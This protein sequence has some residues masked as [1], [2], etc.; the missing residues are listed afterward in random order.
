[1]TPTISNGAFCIVMRTK[2][3]AIDDLVIYKQN[4]YVHRLVAKEGYR[5][6][7]TVARPQCMKGL[8]ITTP[9]F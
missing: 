8:C 1:M 9:G 4:S 3:V 7:Y 2:N 6:Q 5:N